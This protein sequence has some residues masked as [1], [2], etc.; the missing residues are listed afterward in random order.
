MTDLPPLEV[1]HDIVQA[2]L[3][4]MGEL[5]ANLSLLTHKEGT[6]IRILRRAQAEL[7]ALEQAE[8][9]RIRDT[10][11]SDNLIKPG[12]ALALKAEIANFKA[13]AEAALKREDPQTVLPFRDDQDPP[14]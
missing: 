3:Q 6:E 2:R 13:M 12:T 7:Q 4:R 1:P 14:S 5:F 11:L 9:A 8:A 10:F